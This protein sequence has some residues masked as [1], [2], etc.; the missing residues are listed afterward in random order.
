MVLTKLHA[1]GKFDSGAYKVSGGL[2]G[3][4]VSCVNA[5]SEWLEVWVHSGGKIHHMK[6]ERGVRVQELKVVG[7]TDHTGT[8]VRFKPDDEI[9]SVLEIDY[10]IVSKRLREMAYLMGTRGVKIDLLDERTGHKEHLEFPEGLLAFVANVNA[11]KNALHEDVVHFT[12]TVPA[13]DDPKVEYEVE[14][15]LQYTDAYQETVFTFANNINTHGGGTHLAG[16]RAGLTRTLNN[17]A[18][19]EKL[20]KD[21]SKICRPATTSAKA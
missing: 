4:G 19:N 18:K 7:D 21:A 9:F 15:A 16:L 2:H 1:G 20:V 8:R 6:F 5:L 12:K 13:P 10:E 17:Y 14:L 11:K 3:V